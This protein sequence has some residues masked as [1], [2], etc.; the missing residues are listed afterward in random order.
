MSLLTGWPLLSSSQLLTVW[1]YR[2]NVADASFFF[3]S[4]PRKTGSQTV[5]G[6]SLNFGVLVIFQN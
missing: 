2:P 4:P 1:K 5:Y 3:F 6:K